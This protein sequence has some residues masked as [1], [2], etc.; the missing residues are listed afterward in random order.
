MEAQVDMLHFLHNHE[1]DKTNLKTKYNQ[2]CQ[3]MKLYGSRTTKELKKKH[4]SRLLEGVEMGSWS[5]EDTQAR[6]Q[7]ADWVVPHLHANREE[8][9]GSETDLVTQGSNAGKE[10]L[11]TSGCKNLRGLL[12]QE[13]LK[14]HR[15]V[16]L[17]G[18][19]RP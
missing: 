3:K 18:P 5:T 9:L 10:S 4:L 15:R 16:C 2:K 6:Q 13:K 7:L 1:E 8:Q 17:E 14:S 12:W 19:M 11:R